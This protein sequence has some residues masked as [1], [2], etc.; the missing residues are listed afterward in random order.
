MEEKVDIPVLVKQFIETKTQKTDGEYF[1]LLTSSSD[2]LSNKYSNLL[3]I[4][5]FN[6]NKG[7]WFV[8]YSTGKLE[9]D[10][11]DN[12]MANPT[13]LHQTKKHIIFGYE[14]QSGFI[15]IYKFESRKEKPDLLVKFEK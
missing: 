6:E 15:E 8:A 1:K 2:G 3:T 9:L 10:D 13:I 4:K 5:Q 14:T 11:P 12:F 7:V